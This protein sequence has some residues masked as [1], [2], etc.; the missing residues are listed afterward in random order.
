MQLLSSDA[1]APSSVARYNE[2]PLIQYNDPRISFK[3]SMTLWIYAISGIPWV[4][5]PLL[6]EIRII[7]M[8]YLE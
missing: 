8:N 2:V 1:K 6:S 7:R 3:S 4:L 5:T